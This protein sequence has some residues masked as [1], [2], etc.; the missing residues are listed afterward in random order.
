MHSHRV[1]WLL[2]EVAPLAKK[3]IKFDLEKARALALVHDDAEMVTGDIQA[4]VKARI[5]KTEL[6]KLERKELLAVKSLVKKFPKTINGYVYEDLLNHSAKKDCIEAQ[7]VSYV[8]K[9]DAYCESLHEVYAGNISLIRSVIFYANLIP[10]YSK[11]FPA[12]KPFLDSKDSPFT[13]IGDQISPYKIVAKKYS[14]LNKP[15]TKETVKLNN[16][17]YFYKRWKEIVIKHGKIDWLI[18]QRE[19]LPK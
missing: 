11:K 16:D 14:H 3:H 13:F 19:F 12:L 7:L 18:Q 8:D 15:F 9:M 4:I 2:E 6:A 10:L 5:S 1:L 17:F